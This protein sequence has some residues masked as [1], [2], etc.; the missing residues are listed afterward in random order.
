MMVLS[1]HLPG[2]IKENHEKLRIPSVP[3]ETLTE[4]TLD[5]SLVT[6]TSSVS[7]SQYRELSIMPFILTKFKHKAMHYLKYN[8]CDLG[9]TENCNS[10]YRYSILGPFQALLTM[11]AQRWCLPHSGV[12]YLKILYLASPTFRKLLNQLEAATHLTI[13]L[14]AIF[15]C[16]QGYVSKCNKTILMLKVTVFQ[17]DTSWTGESL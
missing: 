3:V 6:Q 10:S 4:H 8:C 12:N 7:G 17:D 1:W 13:Q 5:E 14:S 11:W 2:Q 15:L 16:C 9:I